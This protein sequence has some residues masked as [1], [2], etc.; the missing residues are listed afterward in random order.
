MEGT[1]RRHDP[2]AATAESPKFSFP[3]LQGTCP[4]YGVNK[5]RKE[6]FI[7]QAGKVLED[8]IVPDQGT[9][10]RKPGSLVL[11]EQVKAFCVQR[12]KECALYGAEEKTEPESAGT[13][14]PT[15]T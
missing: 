13:A 4:H 14:F 6:T 11:P 8:I 7:A 2:L 9:C 15:A 12:F 1:D 5:V 10:V 3:V